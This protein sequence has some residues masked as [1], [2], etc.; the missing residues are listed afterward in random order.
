MTI[1]TFEV[2]PLCENCYVVSDDSKDGI[3]IDCGCCS[4]SEWHGILQ[5][6]NT[7]GIHIKHYLCTHLHFDHVWGSS[8]VKRD[9]SLSPQ[10]NIADK[11]LYDNM[12]GMVKE[13]CGV[14]ISIPAMPQ[15][16]DNLRDGDTIRFGNTELMVLS[17][18]GHS[19]GSVCFYS[20]NDNTLFSGDTLFCGG[21]GRTDLQGGSYQQLMQS[22]S[23][24]LTLPDDTKVYCG[25]GPSTT[26]KREK[27]Y[28]YHI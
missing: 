1:K 26:I 5:Y 14:S 4:E 17:T 11:P 10:A 25:H 22:L 27:M 2:N 24:L 20:K 16:G 15:L 6:L 7:Q 18:P 28:N 21:A 9:L 19:Q 12:S 8:Y 13:V 3:I 23:R